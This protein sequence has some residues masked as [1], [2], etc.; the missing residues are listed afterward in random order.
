MQNGTFRV[1][2]PHNEPVLGYA[3]GSPERQAIG[4]HLRCM[5]G[6]T[7]DIPARIGGQ[8]VHTGKTAQAGARHLAPV[9][10]P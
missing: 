5:A 10:P 9:R 4:E 3:P 6:E 8:R 7:I 2:I 1:P